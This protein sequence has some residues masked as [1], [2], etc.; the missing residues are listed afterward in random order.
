MTCTERRPHEQCV[1]R[2]AT[3]MAC[4]L[5]VIFAFLAMV[6]TDAIGQPPPTFSRDIAP[7]LFEHCGGCHRPGQ[8][9]PFSLLTFDDARP[10][11]RAIRQQVATR[12][13]PPWKPEAG[14]GDFTR[15][16]RLSDAQIALIDR[17]VEGGAMEGDRADL[18]RTPRWTE[19][20]QL[21]T[22]DLV[23]EMPE[24]YAVP[25][26]GGDIFRNFAVSV[27]I[28][29]TRYVRAVEFRPDNY[30]VVHHGRILIDSVG[31]ARQLDALDPEPGYSGMLDDESSFPDGHFLGWAP[32]TQP[33]A[34]P[35]GLSWR[36][37][38]GEALVLQLHLL[39]TGVP[40]TLRARVAIYFADGPPSRSA[41]VLR[42]FTQDIDI[43]AG[44]RRHVLEDD[45]VLPIDVDA[46]SVYPHAHYLGKEIQAYAT[47]PS[48]ER[49]WLV[50][51]RDWDFA[52]QDEYEYAEPV[53]LPKGT[54]L[55]ARFTYDN[56]VENPQNPQHPPQRVTYGPG[57]R[58]EMADLG[59][60]VV[61]RRLSELPVL[62][63]EVRRRERQR[64]II[65]QLKRL[66]T[67]PTDPMIHDRLASL[68]IDEDRHDEARAHLQ[69][70]VRLDPGFALA[71][72]HLGNA[73][74]LGQ[75]VHRAITHFERALAVNPDFVQALHHLGKLRL[76]QGR[77]EDAVGLFR[78]ALAINPD[79]AEAHNALGGIFQWLGDLEQATGHFERAV[80]NRPDYA[81]AHHNLA[82]TLALD[83]RPDEGTE[84]FRQAI[85]LDPG[86]P[87]P[88]VELAWVLATSPDA[89]ARDAGEAVRLAERAVQLTGREDPP[90]LDALAAAYANA[91]RYDEAV[92]AAKAALE[93][94]GPQAADQ[95]FGEVR[96][97]LELY[98]Q[99]RPYRESR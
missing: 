82:V 39:P 9:A 61:P 3:R 95:A 74:F 52:W 55:S 5:L 33:R 23:V 47:L 46:L 64:L 59:L 6:P 58:D 18:P 30:R 83:G 76:A 77:I 66:E 19:G 4:S 67:S 36:L 40:E 1:A 93:A 27:P 96:R 34:S 72:F 86:W 13:M 75:E 69:E 92:A 28:S 35:E 7:I 42:L 65:G 91:G 25:T 57:S 17:W 99:R 84:H 32:G 54:V 37:D 51:I 60:Q 43:P 56:S 85:V 50:Y 15:V 44:E 97:R 20:W 62:V 63:D 16:R 53:F 12:Q 26:E 71:H 94:A 24:P 49:K 73:Y 29:R 81:L 79:D 22:P 68:L 41:F 10:W 88:V 70:A 98:T 78:R 31:T 48:G 80:R 89:T 11:A 21:G 90:A 38:P 2:T 87:A 14:H 45:Y 8:F